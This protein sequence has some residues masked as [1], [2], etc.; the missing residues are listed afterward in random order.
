MTPIRRPAPEPQIDALLRY[1]SGV[2]PLAEANAIEAWAAADPDREATIEE[3][4]SAWSLESSPPVWDR[5]GVWRRLE[6][7]SANPDIARVT[8]GVSTTRD[9]SLRMG[10]YSRAATH[11]RRYLAA[12]ATIVIIAAVAITTTYKQS[13]VA[14]QSAVT[15]REVVTHRGQR[16]VLD[17]ADGSRVTLAPDSKLTIPSDFDVPDSRGHYTRQVSLEGRAYFDVVH[18]ATRPFLVRTGSAVTRDIGTSFVL[19]AYPEMHSTQVVVVNGSVGLWEPASAQR[20]APS[21]VNR[22][23]PLMVL[24]RGDVATLDT[25]GTATRIRATKLAAYTSWMEGV[26]VFDH[27]SVREAVRELDRWYDLDIRV[28]DTALLGKHVSATISTETATQAMQHL[29]VAL[30]AEMH[31]SGRI[32]RLVPR[33]VRGSRAS[34]DSPQS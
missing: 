28:S 5:E 25:N 8:H 19:T 22:T 26:L 27:T 15:T 12:A 13:P 20:A 29:A 16:A 32:V 11:G 33:S 1:V 23:S 17:L 9:R 24:G 6:A 2:S 7:E 18:D 4:R 10:R 30:D 31:K 3:I 21:T 34:S 14:E